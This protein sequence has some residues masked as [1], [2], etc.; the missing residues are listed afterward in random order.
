MKDSFRGWPVIVAAG[1]EDVSRVTW[2]SLGLAVLF[3]VLTARVFFASLEEF[4]NGL[5][6]LGR[7]RFLRSTDEDW[8]G[9]KIWVWILLSA[10]V[11]FSAHYQLP[12]WFP[13]FFK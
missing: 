12:K 5:S 7:R 3:A 8:S 9:L 13:D 6:N 10:A 2:V 11:G 1:L 4:G